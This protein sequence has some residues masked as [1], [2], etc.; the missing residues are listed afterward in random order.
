MSS[1]DTPLGPKDLDFASYLPASALAGKVKGKVEINS[2]GRV[3][4]I[5][6]PPSVCQSFAMML[7]ALQVSSRK[8][9]NNLE[10]LQKT[11]Y[12]ASLFCAKN[13]ARPMRVVS[14]PTWWTSTR[15]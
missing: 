5:S 6:P 3:L 14:L 9:L 2:G 13:S 4:S 7:R 10:S 11:S 12:H 8:N 15:W 1:S